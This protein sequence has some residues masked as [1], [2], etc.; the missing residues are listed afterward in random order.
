MTRRSVTHGLLCL[1]LSGVPSRS[2][3]Q[4]RVGRQ[5]TKR[6]EKKLIAVGWDMPNAERLRANYE[7]MDKLPFRGSSLR[8]TGRNNTP[9]LDFAHSR[10]LW[11]P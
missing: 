6:V 2:Y 8:F 1:L 3:A 11:K 4:N 5:G 9:F 10:E 7:V